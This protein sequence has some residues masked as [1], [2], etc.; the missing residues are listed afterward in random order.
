MDTL[1]TYKPKHSPLSK[2]V[3]YDA[4]ASGY[5]ADLATAHEILKRMLESEEGKKTGQ[6]LIRNQINVL[7]K[8]PRLDGDAEIMKELEKDLSQWKAN[9]KQPHKEFNL[10]WAFLVTQFWPHLVPAL[11][12]VS[13]DRSVTVD[14]DLTTSLPSDLFLSHDNQ[15]LFSA[16]IG[17]NMPPDVMISTT[18]AV[19]ASS[20]LRRAIDLYLGFGQKSRDTENLTFNGQIA[21]IRFSY[22]KKYLEMVKRQFLENRVMTKNRKLIL[23]P[24]FAIFDGKNHHEMFSSMVFLNRSLSENNPLRDSLVRLLTHERYKNQFFGDITKADLAGVPPTSTPFNQVKVGALMW[25]G[26][27]FQEITSLK[28]FFDVTKQN[29]TVKSFLFCLYALRRDG[30][31]NVILLY[32]VDK[33]TMDLADKNVMKLVASTKKGTYTTRT[34]ANPSRLNAYAGSDDS[35]DGANSDSEGDSSDSDARN[36]DSDADSGSDNE[37]SLSARLY[38]Q[39]AR[40][41]KDFVPNP[42]ANEANKLVEGASFMDFDREDSDAIT[43]TS[44]SSLSVSTMISTSLSASSGSSSSTKASAPGYQP[45]NPPVGG[46]YGDELNKV[47]VLT[48]P[49]NLA[50]LPGMGALGNMIIN[51]IDNNTNKNVIDHVGLMT[52]NDQEFSVHIERSAVFQD[53]SF[54]VMVVDAKESASGLLS[55]SSRKGGR[56]LKPFFGFLR[57]VDIDN[58]M[59]GYASSSSS[60]SSD[61]D[62]KKINQDAPTD[63]FNLGKI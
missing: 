30:D 55:S 57:S 19:K 38:T 34:K 59:A 25:A 49:D 37:R 52:L 54:D 4:D 39:R 3:H 20:S 21:I 10:C 11:T 42:K 46:I 14:K 1:P 43:P 63:Y 40:G 26:G 15:G 36:S 45:L 9:I 6:E 22:D 51:L 7:K 13:A 16:S 41:Y 31:K 28:S 29:K 58:K 32:F 23:R 8:K 61:E 48:Y 50:G 17:F 27:I 56:H 60:S 2:W 24:T 12:Y 35:D 33:K 62:D 47:K 18:T 53:S 5:V 44:V